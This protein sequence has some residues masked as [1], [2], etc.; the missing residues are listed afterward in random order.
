MATTMRSGARE[1]GKAARGARSSR[2]AQ[3]ETGRAA[4]PRRQ[5]GFT[6]VELMVVVTILGIL[7]GIASIIIDPSPDLRSVTGD[8]KT[9]VAEAA[10]NAVAGGPVR[11]DVAEAEGTSARARLFIASEGGDQFVTVQRRVEDDDASSSVW[12]HVSRIHLPRSVEVYGYDPDHA[13]LEAGGEPTRKDGDGIEILCRPTG[14]CGP[15]TLY[16]QTADG[17]EQSRLAILE[18]AGAPVTFSSW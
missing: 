9:R 1:V 17:T 13:R 10:R 11:A 14:S 15:A 8:V 3:I 4:P 5:R 7:A 12:R 16:L 18:F 6:L 2:E